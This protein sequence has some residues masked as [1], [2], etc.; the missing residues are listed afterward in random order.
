MICRGHYDHYTVIADELLD[1]SILW[2][3]HQLQIVLSSIY[4]QVSLLSML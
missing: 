2:L 1:R 4:V 3:P